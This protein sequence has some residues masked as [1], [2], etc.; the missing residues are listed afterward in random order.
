MNLKTL[1]IIIPCYN[2]ET[3]IGIVIQKVLSS[4]VLGFKKEI[5]VV[6]DGSTDST[7]SKI[8]EFAGAIKK[9]NY[10]ENQ[11]KGYAIRK[12]IEYSHGEIILIQDAD[13]EYDPINFPNLLRPFVQDK[14]SVVYGI[15]HREPLK[16][17]NLFNMY[18]LGGVLINKMVNVLFRYKVQDIHVGYKVFKRELLE[19]IKLKSNGFSVCHE[20][21]ILLI[22]NK[23]PIVEVPITYYPRKVSEGKKIAF[24]DGILITIYVLFKKMRTFL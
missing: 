17:K 10:S 5:I 15:R 14:A 2:E 11:G 16:V 4:D 24:K 8:N 13:L 3:T 19:N 23:I 6:N 21:T 18:F 12:G 7:E 9:I 20:L 22:Q 1:T